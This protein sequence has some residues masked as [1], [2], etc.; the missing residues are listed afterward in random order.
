MCLALDLVLFPDIQRVRLKSPVFITG[1]PRSGTTF[2]HRVLTTPPPAQRVSRN[3]IED[4]PFVIHAL[5]E[6]LCPALCL[7]Y[8][9]YPVIHLIDKLVGAVWGYDQLKGAYD[10]SLNGEA[11]E[12]GL[13]GMHICAGDFWSEFLPVGFWFD[14]SSRYRGNGLNGRVHVRFLKSLLQRQVFWSGKEQIVA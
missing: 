1:C 3:L 5:W 10:L 4:S 13:F 9:V 12:E 6:I 14:L 8:C 2:T 7:K 11:A